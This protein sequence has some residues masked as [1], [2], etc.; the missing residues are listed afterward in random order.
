MFS[1]PGWITSIS[2]RRTELRVRQLPCSLLCSLET[3]LHSN[4]PIGF[5]TE[6]QEGRNCT[7]CPAGAFASARGT[8]S[9]AQCEPGNFAEGAANNGCTPCPPNTHGPSRGLG[10]CLRCEQDHDLFGQINC[11]AWSGRQ[12]AHEGSQ[13]DS[14]VP[15]PATNSFPWLAL[16]GLLAIPLAMISCIIYRRN[17]KVCVAMRRCGHAAHHTDHLLADGTSAM[18]RTPSCKNVLKSLSPL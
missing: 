17:K 7:E 18:T 11:R 9:C 16:L 15:D 10:A 14:F 5:H 8:E 6:G 2:K 13:T 4:C 3:R 12:A 1:M